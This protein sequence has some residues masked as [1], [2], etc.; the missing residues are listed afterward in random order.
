MSDTIAPDIHNTL[1]RLLRQE[2]GRLLAA[3]N[4]NLRDLQLSEDCL[5]DALESALHHWHRTGTPKNPF[6]WLLQVARRKAI[7]RL[8]YVRLTQNKEDEISHLMALDQS[9][10]DPDFDKIHDHWLRM[11]FTCCHPAL[12]PKT[13]VALT[14]RTL[15]GLTT[16]E[17]AGAFLDKPETMAQRLARA[18]K[19]IRLRMRRARR[20]SRVDPRCRTNYGSAGG[21]LVHQ[22]PVADP[23]AGL[24]TL[25]IVECGL[26][27]RYR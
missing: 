22:P 2:R 7:D 26:D 18:K 9:P 25:P 6:S 11:I 1:N 8:R 3:L 14:L 19:K 24:P 4:A 12:D 5:Q 17:I 20:C 21:S 13:R 10:E 23:A 27:W 16:E 15:G